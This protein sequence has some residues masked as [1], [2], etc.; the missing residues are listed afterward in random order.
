[1][2]GSIWSK[3][4]LNAGALRFAMNLWPPFV[5]AGIRVLDIAPDHRSA[6][7]RLC[8][9][10]YNRNYNG[11]QFGGSLYAMTDAFFAMILIWNLGRGYAVWD[12]EARIQYKR[13][14]RGAVTASFVLTDAQIAEVRAKTASGEKFEPTYRVDVVDAAGQV[15]ATVDKTIYI[16][17]LPGAAELG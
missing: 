9:R 8:M 7:V 3:L 4:K 11:T 16:R 5:G 2:S 15:V 12:K 14:G 17:R 1:M 13:P 10:W 6:K